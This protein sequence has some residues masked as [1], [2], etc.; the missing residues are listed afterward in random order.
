VLPT[1][2]RRGVLRA[3]MR[4]QLDD[5]HERGEPLAAL[6]ASEETIY[7]RY[8][9]GL[10]SLVHNMK[11]PRAHSD[12]QPGFHGVGQVRI[13][14]AADA[15]AL[16]APV[17]DRVQAAT[18][19]MH[20][21]TASWWEHRMLADPPEWRQGAGP[22]VF[23]VLDVDGEPFGYAIYRLNVSFGDLGPE[24]T[25]QVIEAVGSTPPATAS[26]W[27]FL[28]DVDWTQTVAARLL[29]VDHPLL[30]L[31]ARPNLAGTTV[32]DGL[33]VRLVDVGAALSVRGYGAGGAVVFEV[34]DAFCDWN[35]GRWLLADGEATRTDRDPDLRLDV[36]VL[37]SAYLG[38]LTF[39][40]LANAGRVEELREGA[41]ARADALFR[42]DIA[43]WS[44]E[45]F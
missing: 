17:Y 37:G 39:R 31:L 25:L 9:Y 45:I 28:L 3:M 11:I 1:H 20:A 2:R 30:L 35:T 29:P 5:V 8:G 4:A 24:T 44:P 41:L 33:W 32:H 26:I 40:E 19:G 10:A 34:A 15:Y 16:V 21:R 38:G 27:R 43:P 13:V 6:W 23:A 12:F 14:E 7:G 36:D 18:P 22:K 42:S